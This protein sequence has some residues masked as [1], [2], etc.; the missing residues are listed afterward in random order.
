V[1][2]AKLDR[3]EEHGYDPFFVVATPS[4]GKRHALP[5]ADEH[6]RLSGDAMRPLTVPLP[7]G[8]RDPQATRIDAARLT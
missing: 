1:R 8:E 2:Q 7:C 3:A 6:R 5:L 4:P